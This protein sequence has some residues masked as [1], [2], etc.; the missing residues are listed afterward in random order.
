VIVAG[1]HGGAGTTTIAQL[2]GAYDAGVWPPRPAP[3]PV[4]LVARGTP[5]GIV[6]ANWWLRAARAAGV[7]PAALIIVGDGPWPEPRLATLRLRM[8]HG[9]VPTV[10]RLPYIPHWRY[11][12]QPLQHPLPKKLIHAL[13][14]LRAAVQ[15]DFPRR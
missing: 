12:D 15:P 13:E 4:L 6:R 9:L 5:Q 10:V 1:C 3:Y 7:G 14:R 2:I 11:L 8:L